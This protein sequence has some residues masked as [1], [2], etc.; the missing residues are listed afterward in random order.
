MEKALFE[1]KLS[2]GELFLIFAEAK[3]NPANRCGERGPGTFS[4]LEG[5]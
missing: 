1:F 4:L 5:R 3:R 2:T